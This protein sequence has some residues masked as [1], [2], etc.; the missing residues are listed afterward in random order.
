[1]TTAAGMRVSCFP[2]KVIY[3]AA[4]SVV[5]CG[6]TSRG[7]LSGPIRSAHTSGGATRSSALFLLGPHRRGLDVIRRT[8]AWR[9]AAAAGLAADRLH[10]HV[11][12]AQDLAAQAEARMDA[13]SAQFKQL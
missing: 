13:E 3:R 8:V 2:P 5:R 11:V 6:T 1:M 12:V 10:R 4:Y 9:R 7:P